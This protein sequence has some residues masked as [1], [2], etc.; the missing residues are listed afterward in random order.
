M[1]LAAVVGLE[2]EAR[3]LRRRGI[4]VLA[5]GAD[6]A[7]ARA[8]AESQ[9]AAGAGALVS[10]GISGA[11]DPALATGTILLP[12]RVV[13]ETGEVFVADELLRNEIARGLGARGLVFD[14]RDLLGRDGIV[15]T[16]SEKAT[17]F[18]ATGAVAVDLESHIAARAVRDRARFVALRA[19]ADGAGFD[20]PSAAFVGLHRDGRAAPFAVLRALARAP[21]QLPALVRL[22]LLTRAALSALARS[23]PALPGSG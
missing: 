9:L 18:R 15:A 6:P 19:V 1:R 14:A 3:I 4:A 11:L 2:A 8:L 16:A 10:F 17:L 22:A 5:S 7:R 21:A 23:A 12:R 20:L 13:T